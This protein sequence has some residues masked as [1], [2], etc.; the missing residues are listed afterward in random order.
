MKERCRIETQYQILAARKCQDR[1]YFEKVNNV[2]ASFLHALNYRHFMI[3]PGKKYH[4][5]YNWL[6]KYERHVRVEINLSY[7]YSHM[8]TGREWEGDVLFTEI[9]SRRG[10]SSYPEIRGDNSLTIKVFRDIRHGRYIS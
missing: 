8:S 3:L 4:V 2:Y 10:N 9:D 7:R 1:A 6:L 5:V